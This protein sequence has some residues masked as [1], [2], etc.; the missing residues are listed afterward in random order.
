VDDTIAA[1]L[2]SVRSRIDA[3]AHRAGRDP[4]DI[5]LVAVS[6]TF[7]AD[8][9]RAAW[10]AGHRDFGENKV[11]EALQKIAETAEKD[12]KWHLIGHLQSNKAKKAAAGFACIHAVDSVDLLRKLD[13]AAAEQ[14]VSPEVL[15]QVDL[16]GE[17][18]KFGAPADQARRVLDAGLEARAVRLSGLMLIPPWNEDQ[19]QT[20][21]WFVRL[22]ML[23]DGWLES[24]VP[25]SAL[26]HLSMGMSHDF[27]AAVEEGATLVRV[28]TAIFGKRTV[29]T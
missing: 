22:R 12:L 21:P 15:I 17:T 4:S 28:G 8:H 3:A 10:A 14:G 2:R 23:R 5:L 27:E 25:S 1:N 9:V 6:K 29:R 13:Q 20:R 11:Q 7:S 26:R 16:A 24:G 18:T 19:E